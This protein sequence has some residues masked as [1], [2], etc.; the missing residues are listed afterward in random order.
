MIRVLVPILVLSLTTVATAA[1]PP[2]KSLQATVVG[3]MDG[4][5][6]KV[7]DANQVEYKI[8]LAGIDA[9]GER[10]IDGT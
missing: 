10:E 5:T 3:V 7:L 2:T 9:P 1:V 4:D 8:R 6:V